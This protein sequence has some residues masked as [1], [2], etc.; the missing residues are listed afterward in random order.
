[1]VR[2]MV[3]V[4]VRV[5]LDT[6]TCLIEGQPALGSSDRPSKLL[7]GTDLSGRIAV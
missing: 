3:R 6:I 1:L 4:R 7:I 2:I 5:R